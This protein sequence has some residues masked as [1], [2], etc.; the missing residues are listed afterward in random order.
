[1][2][3]SP[4]RANW[5]ERWS[6]AKTTSL[7]GPMMWVSFVKDGKTQ[8]GP[9]VMVSNNVLY[10]A[11]ANKRPPRGSPCLMPKDDSIMVI[12]FHVVHV[13][14]KKKNEHHKTTW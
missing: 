11:K 9:L 7:I 10:W 6:K 4:T 3:L 8:L 1:L 5:V 2:T 12:P 14:S 13:G